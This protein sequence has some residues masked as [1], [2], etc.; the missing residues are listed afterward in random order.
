M[1]PGGSGLS[2]AGPQA[3]SPCPVSCL[4][5]AGSH[6]SGQLP[7]AG[8]LGAAA[9]EA[10]A[11]SPDC[12]IPAAGSGRPGFDVLFLSLSLSLQPLDFLSLSFTRSSLTPLLL[13]HPLSHSTEVQV[14][15]QTA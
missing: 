10:Q 14:E 2:L 15:L 1:P 3:G 12:L 7:G 4:P 13:S 5:A 8:A 6:S 9:E 11:W